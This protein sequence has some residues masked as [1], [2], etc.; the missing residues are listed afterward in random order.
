MLKTNDRRKFRLILIKPSHYDNRGYVIQWHRS[1]IPA[2]SLACVYG[3]ADAANRNGAF[4][5][6]ELDII[7]IDETNTRIEPKKIASRIRE[8]G[9]GM[10]ML[11]GVQSNQFPRALDIAGPLREAGIKVGIGGFHVS[12]TIAMLKGHDPD[13]QKALDMGCYLFAGEAEEGRLEGVIRDGITGQLKQIYNFMNDLPAMDGAPPPYLPAE[14]VKK[15]FASN[16]SFDAGRGCPYQCSFCTIIN[17]QG[18]KSRHR[19]PDDVEA[20]IRANLDQ[21]I[22]RFF[23]TDD[24]FAR[25]THWEEIFDRLIYLREVQKL[26]FRC[27][28]QVDTGCHK[29]PNF[30]EKAS[31]AGVRRV[32]IGL[33]NIN[34]ANLVGAKKRQNKITE[35]RTMLL[36][37]KKHGVTNY[38][39]YITGFPTDTKERILSDVKII[40]EELPVDVLEFFYLTPLPGSEDHKKQIEAGVWMDPDLNKYDLDHRVSHHPLMSDEDW[41]TAYKQ[42]WDMYYSKTHRL[43][44]M[45][46]N[47]A[48]GISPG[49]TGFLLN[50]FKGAYTIEEVHPLETGFRRKRYRRDRRPGMKIENPFV[51]YGRQILD[52]PVKTARWAW[53]W[54]SLYPAYRGIKAGMKANKKRYPYMDT[55]LEPVADDGDDADRAMYQN[56]DARAYIEKAKKMDAIRANAS[57]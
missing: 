25:N 2:N 42:A 5:E 43:R 57:A 51:F 39:G 44:V 34:P 48:Y 36:E 11:I 18:R 45:K 14:T 6:A 46:R 41:E 40:M 50:F 47:A 20:I 4:P 12:G 9:D 49:K 38:C 53:L 33:E 27:I 26:P 13:V 16:T 10:V 17:V 28:I 37:W 56:E 3:L 21:K 24:N 54:I 31:R 8:A 35:Y 23:I 29:I 19:T 55:A 32:F 22:Y 52:T 30:I 1:P 15:T 7:A